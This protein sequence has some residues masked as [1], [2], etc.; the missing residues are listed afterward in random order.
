M[1]GFFSLVKLSPDGGTQY[2]LQPDY[3]F[4]VK[5]HGAVDPTSGD[6]FVHGKLPNFDDANT[7]LSYVKQQPEYRSLFQTTVPKTVFKK[8]SS[9]APIQPATLFRVKMAPSF[10]VYRHPSIATMITYYTQ[11][12]IAL[13]IATENTGTLTEETLN[14][15]FETVEQRQNAVLMNVIQDIQAAGNV[16]QMV[17]YP[18]TFTDPAT[19]TQDIQVNSL[20]II[21]IRLL[22]YLVAKLNA[23]IDITL[24]GETVSLPIG[25]PLMRKGDS[26]YPLTDDDLNGFYNGKRLVKAKPAAFMEQLNLTNA[27]FNAGLDLKPAYGRFGATP[28]QGPIMPLPPGP[29]EEDID[30][31]VDRVLGRQTPENAQLRDALRQAL[32]RLRQQRAEIEQLQQARLTAE[33]RAQLIDNL[34]AQIRGFNQTLPGVFQQNEQLRAQIAALQAAGTGLGPAP[35]GGPAPPTTAPPTGEPDLLPLPLPT[36]APPAGPTPPPAPEEPD[37]APQQQEEPEPAVEQQTRTAPVPEPDFTPEPPV[38]TEQ[39]QPDL[40][41]VPYAGPRETPTPAIPSGITMP[42]ERGSMTIPSL[43]TLPEPERRS[44]PLFID[45]VNIPEPEPSDQEVPAPPPASEPAAPG[46]RLTIEEED[47]AGEEIPE[48]ALRRVGTFTLPSP[49]EML[50]PD[51]LPASDAG[52]RIHS[53]I[54]SF[55]KSTGVKG[56]EFESAKDVEKRIAKT[57]RQ[58]VRPGKGPATTPGGTPSDPVLQQTLRIL[59]PDYKTLQEAAWTA[60]KRQFEVPGRSSL[61]KPYVLLTVKVR[62]DGTVKVSSNIVQTGGAKDLYTFEFVVLPVTTEIPEETEQAQ[63]P[64]TPPI[65]TPPTVAAPPMRRPLVPQT[66]LGQRPAPTP[67]VVQTSEPVDAPTPAPQTEPEQIPMSAAAASSAIGATVMAPPTMIPATEVDEVQVEDDGWC[68]YRS[69]FNAARGRYEGLNTPTPPEEKQELLEFV[70]QIQQW[71]RDNQT[72]PI[73][74]QAANKFPKDIIVEGSPVRMETLEEYVNQLD[75]LVGDNNPA[76]Y[77]E[78]DIG[79]GDAVANLLERPIE[80][81][82][83][84]YFN[85]QEGIQVEVYDR[86]IAFPGGINAEPIR[87]VSEG[88]NH[89]NLL[90][91]KPETPVTRSLPLSRVRIP[92]LPDTQ[93]EPEQERNPL[94]GQVNGG[95]RRRRT[96]KRGARR[97]HKAAYKRTRRAQTK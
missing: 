67:P 53:V 88:G 45:D 56:A 1:P 89:Y 17:A 24:N 5:L 90:K 95:R 51:Q 28:G 6:V 3:A 38:Q 18:A 70:R 68:F 72:N 69:V 76:M 66:T 21:Q 65:A 97:S 77:A 4:L 2:T 33:Q 58:F 94:P 26:A 81:Y 14:E 64:E 93:S 11:Y 35:T 80:M 91:K 59:S 49:N 87:I 13:G 12:M 15:S 82:S 48:Q 19:Q 44:P 32:E 22:P 9:L 40:S 41:M 83:P 52:K 29:A 8:T 96:F 31:I 60:K 62:D 86:L 37:V 34:H 27:D 10:G 25:F 75:R 85:P 73:I 39:V 71:I 50:L 23:P 74:E 55:V 79:V 16:G 57:L 20:Y 92:I 47:G 46:R 84:K 42:L 30:D 54:K 78:L 61:P 36:T 7:I 63:V 43:P